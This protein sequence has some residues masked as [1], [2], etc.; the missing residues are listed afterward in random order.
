MSQST[1]LY[2]V[3]QEYFKQLESSGLNRKFRI[4]SAKSFSIFQGSEMGIEFIL[5]KANN[6]IEK[7][8]IKEIFN[9]QKEL[10]EE[11]LKTATPEE[12]F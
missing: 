10:G 12:Q 8:L 2:R 7:E 6:E 9:P 3:S 11:L 1:T 4:D 5:M